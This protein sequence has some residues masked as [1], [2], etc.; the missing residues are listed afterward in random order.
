MKWSEH[1]KFQK[2]ASIIGYASAAV[3]VVLAILEMTGVLPN[4]YDVARIFF[5]VGFAGLSTQY[6]K[7]QKAMAIAGLVLG[8]VNIIMSIVYLLI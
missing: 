8:A 5:G 7:S 6:W 4:I 1:A 3:Y 2:I